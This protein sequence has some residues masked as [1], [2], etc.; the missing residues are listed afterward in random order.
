MQDLENVVTEEDELV[1]KELRE[2]MRF[3]THDFFTK[4]KVQVNVYYVR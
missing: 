1:L 2:R 3:M 4:Q